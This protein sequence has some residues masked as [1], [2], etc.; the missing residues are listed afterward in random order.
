MKTKVNTL[1]Y[2]LF[3]LLAAQP[4]LATTCYVNLNNASPMPP[5]TNWATAATNIQD[6]VD[7]AMTGDTVLVTNGVYANG[8]RAVY[9]Q[10]TNRVAVNKPLTLLSVNGPAMTV[11]VGA[12]ASSGRLGDGAIRCA[13][14]GTNAVFCG[15]TMTTG[16]TRAA[17]DIVR[18]QSGGGV[19]C[20]V[21]G[22]V[23]NCTL[24]ANQASYYGGGA[25]SGRLN[26]CTLA[27]N[28]AL[29]KGGGA[30]DNVLQECVLNNCTLIGNTAGDAGG[31]ACY[32]ILN[33][34]NLSGN[35]ASGDGGGGAAFSTLNNCSITEN[36][37]TEG[38]GASGCTLNSCTICS[39]LASVGGGAFSGT[40]NNC[41]MSGNSAG[42]GGGASG[43]TLS[44]CTLVGNAASR[45]GGG[46]YYGSLNNCILYYNTAPIGAEWKRAVASPPPSK[47][48]T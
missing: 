31:G 42:F 2:G 15:F 16:Y 36:S 30:S 32:A 39:N 12:A 8:G 13:Y 28:V 43:G 35:S 29:W 11:I 18:E 1:T 23:S 41:T 24:I 19:W 17:G 14:V 26:N 45:Q 10:M 3:L 25:Y 48:R 27:T 34:C 21:S 6:A 4:S 40:L 33:Y 22:V 44:H 37:A 46:G 9:G 7:A 5:Y 20:E 47:N 38:G